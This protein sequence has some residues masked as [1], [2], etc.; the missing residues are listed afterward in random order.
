M[1]Y[2]TDIGFEMRNAASGTV[3]MNRRIGY[4]TISILAFNGAR[5]EK[6]FPILYAKSSVIKTKIWA[7][8]EVAVE[9]RRIVAFFI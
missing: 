6:C 2:L 9:F 5:T 3:L 7:S 8:A 4:K 1:K